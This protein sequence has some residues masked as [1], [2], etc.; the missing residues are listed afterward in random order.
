MT[1][2]AVL[3]KGDIGRLLV[4]QGKAWAGR[5][6]LPTLDVTY[7]E[8]VHLLTTLLSEMGLS[9]FRLGEETIL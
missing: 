9:Y 8:V 5:S 7:F 4:W 6:S 1:E 2:N 3:G